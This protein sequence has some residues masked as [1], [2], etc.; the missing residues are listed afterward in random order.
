MWERVVQLNGRIL[1]YGRGAAQVRRQFTLGL[2]DES[3]TVKPDY[4]RC[5]D[6]VTRASLRQMVAPVRPAFYALVILSH[7]SGASSATT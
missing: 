3:T 2:L 7:A 6:I 1:K 5:V 4:A